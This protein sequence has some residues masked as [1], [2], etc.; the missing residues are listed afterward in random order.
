LGSFGIIIM[1]F[2]IIF[3]IFIV[4]FLVHEIIKIKKLKCEYFK[5][6]WNLNEFLIVTFS[7]VSMAMFAM[8]TI[9]TNL[10]IKD[11]HKTEMAGFVNFN[12]LAQWNEIYTI[13]VSIIVFCASLKFLKLLRFNK[14]IGMLASTLRYAAKDLL[15]F[16]FTFGVF[17]FAFTMVS[18]CLFG[19][20]MDSYKSFMSALGS[21]FRF[22]LGQ[23]DFKGL[24]DANLI[25]GAIYFVSFILIVIMGLMS[26]F[27][28]ILSEAFE[29]VKEDLKTQKN[30]HELLS[31]ISGAIKNL[32]KKS[33][34]KNSSKK[35]KIE[36]SKPI[37]PE[38]I[39]SSLDI[40]SLSVTIKEP[41]SYS[42]NL[43]L[44]NIQNMDVTLSNKNRIPRRLEPLNSRFTN[45][46][47]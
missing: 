2:Q 18:Y 47:E 9:F 27:V 40:Q 41:V 44:K 16:S 28:A 15:S 42:S 32:K 13:I 7:I 43:N 22:A 10:A 34:K 25:L 36:S 37:D 26:M 4:Y 8:R 11:V 30:E 19:P 29:K 39:V 46:Y 17:F 20:Y 31:F 6:F 1:I 3:V 33:K 23:Y 21:Q 35:N 5:H 12:T 24:I 38:E 45:I 14:R